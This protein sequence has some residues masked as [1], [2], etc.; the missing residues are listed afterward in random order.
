MTGASEVAEETEAEADALGPAPAL[1]P[2]GEPR[3][4][5]EA[6]CPGVPLAADV[7]TVRLNRGTSAVAARDSA[8]V[9]S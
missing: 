4:L 9:G 3:R 8:G 2:P 1:E 7:A 6:T 5:P